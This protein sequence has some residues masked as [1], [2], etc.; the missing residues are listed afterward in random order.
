MGGT[1]RLGFCP[2]KGRFYIFTRLRFWLRNRLFT[3]SALVRVFIFKFWAVYV[4]VILTEGS[5]FFPRWSGWLILVV[6]T[7]FE[8][9]VIPDGPIPSF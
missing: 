8:V 2:L 6:I 9:R 3:F 7:L 5:T 1:R 4:F